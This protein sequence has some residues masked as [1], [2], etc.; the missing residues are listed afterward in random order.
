[1]NYSFF[2]LSLIFLII[3]IF[4]IL[5]NCSP[6]L[7]ANTFN[8]INK[9]SEEKK[10]FFD[11]KKMDWC[12]KLRNNYENIRD[13]YFRYINIEKKRLI[14]MRDI[15]KEQAII[16]IS[17]SNWYVI[18]LKLCGNFTNNIK[19]FPLTYDLI[20]QIPGCTTAM[21]S[22]LEPWKKIPKHCGPYNGVLRYHLTLITDKN[23]NRE[24]FI[25]VDGTKY[26]WKEGEDVLFDDCYEHYVENNTNTI[27]VVLF[28]DIEKEFETIFL[29]YINKICLHCL[30][31]NINIKKEYITKINHLME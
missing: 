24:C 28:L 13:E 26:I 16:D 19:Y 11:T 18:Y 31:Y 20:L 22:I 1:M 12:I 7:L 14:R 29:K 25:V 8:S 4:Y 23:N 30:K 27:R 3:N 17:D 6:Y 5:L 15:D 10:V 9:Y 21:F 2:Y